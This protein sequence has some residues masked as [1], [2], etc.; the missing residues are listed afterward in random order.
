[1]DEE[2]APYGALLKKKQ[3]AAYLSVG[4]RTVDRMIADGTLILY[5]VRDRIFRLKKSDLDELIDNLPP[6]MG[7]RPG[8]GE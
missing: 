8:D 2:L 5:Q 6:G 7:S 1:M 3:G 4:E